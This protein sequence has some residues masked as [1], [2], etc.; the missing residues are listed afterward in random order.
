MNACSSWLL[1]LEY[2]LFIILRWSF[3]SN[4]FSL[5]Y[6]YN[7]I[8]VNVKF[9]EIAL[10]NLVLT[11]VF[12]CRFVLKINNIAPTECVNFFFRLTG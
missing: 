7:Y 12:F 11:E 6:L 4:I 2:V 1:S 5:F 9:N 10:N 8:T 3:F